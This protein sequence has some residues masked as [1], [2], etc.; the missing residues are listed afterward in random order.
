MPRSPTWGPGLSCFMTVLDIKNRA[1]DR[2]GEDASSPGRYSSNLL[3]TFIQEAQQMWT[4]AVGG[5]VKTETVSILDDTLEYT[6]TAD[7]VRIISVEVLGTDYDKWLIPTTEFELYESQ[8]FGRD[9]RW[10]TVKG[11]RPWYYVWHN[12]QT[13]WLWPTMSNAAST[14]V[15]VTYQY[16]EDDLLSVNNDS[17]IPSVP[18]EF[19]SAIV[20]WVVGRA[21]LLATGDSDRIERAMNLMK[22]WMEA[23]NTMNDR[24]IP[25]NAKPQIENFGS[26]R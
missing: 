23:L 15:K 2:L 10:R 26:L 14:Q 4:L 17:E 19:H 12:P 20:D 6:L 24:K 9:R 25:G 5:R 22:R 21:L 8:G 18:K 7:P 3:S 16:E 13:L 11:E 1:W